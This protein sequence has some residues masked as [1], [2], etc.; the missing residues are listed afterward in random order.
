MMTM[1]KTFLGLLALASGVEVA[2]ADGHAGP[3]AMT[4][5]AALP[6]GTVDNGRQGLGTLVD[7]SKPT[8]I[9]LVTDQCA[10]T[11]ANLAELE[12]MAAAH[13]DVNFVAVLRYLSGP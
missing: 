9:H 4:G 10:I 8:V 12:K 7:T 3:E 13:G 11:G 5:I 6:V 1:A 2:R